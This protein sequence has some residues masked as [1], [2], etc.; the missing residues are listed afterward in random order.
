M[1]GEEGSAKFCLA[2]QLILVL[3]VSHSKDSP[4]LLEEAMDRTFNV[5]FAGLWPSSCVLS[6]AAPA[7]C[8]PTPAAADP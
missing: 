5:D 8:P 2:M 3:L 6:S 7:W 1:K 4:L